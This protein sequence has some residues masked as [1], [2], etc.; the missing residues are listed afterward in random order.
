[1]ELCDQLRLGERIRFLGHRDDVPEILA[2][3]DVFAF[4][5]VYEELGGAVIEAM[6][7][8]LPI[9]ASDIPALRE[10]VEDGRN[11][12]LVKPE[13]ST[14][15]AAGLARILDDRA[16]ASTFGERSLEIFR[17]RFTIERSARRMID[18]YSRVA[19]FG[20]GAGQSH[21]PC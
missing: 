6:A 16:L 11:G 2:A 8:G 9:V 19:C 18:L 21:T 7:L 5:S 13:S 4:P 10:V 3:A 14:A 12:L 15:L 20:E 1:M 17:Q